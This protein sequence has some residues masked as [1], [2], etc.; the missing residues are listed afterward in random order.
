MLDERKLYCYSRTNLTPYRVYFFSYDP[1][2]C[3][4]S[5]VTLILHLCKI[6]ASIAWNIQ[7]SPFSRLLLLRYNIHR[8]L[9][10]KKIVAEWRITLVRVSQEHPDLTYMDSCKNKG[11][12]YQPHLPPFSVKEVWILIWL[13]WFFGAEPLYELGLGDITKIRGHV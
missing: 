13:I 7:G 9:K 12:L 4:L 3:C 10:K 6:M 5:S 2:L 1:C 8:D 11:L